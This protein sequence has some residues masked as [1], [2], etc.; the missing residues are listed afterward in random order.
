MKRIVVFSVLV[1][2]VMFAFVS[3]GSAWAQFSPGKE[4]SGADGDTTLQIGQVSPGKAVLITRNIY[5]VFLNGMPIPGGVQPHLTEADHSGKGTSRVVS[6]TNPALAKLI[7]CWRGAGSDWEK[8]VCAT[9]VNGESEVVIDV[10][11]ARGQ[12]FAFIP[13]LV[14]NER[15]RTVIAWGSHPANTR[16]LLACSLDSGNAVKDMLSVF[17]VDANGLIRVA[18][19]DEAARYGKHYAKFCGIGR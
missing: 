16:K 5:G 19:D 18:T 7:F 10:G 9:I 3:G 11:A 1:L 14:E 2:F 12:V 8:Q 17:S 6:T 15:A 13:V 4:A